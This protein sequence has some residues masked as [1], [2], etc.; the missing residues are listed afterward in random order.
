[1]KAVFVVGMMRSGTSLVEQIIASHPAVA[2]AGELSFWNDAVRKYNAL[3]RQEPL[4]ESL[5]RQLAEGYLQA[6]E[7]HSVDASRVVDKA[8]INSNYLGVIHSVFPNARIIYMRRDPIDTCLSCYFQPLSVSHSFTLDL[9]DL[10]HYYREHQRLMAH[11]R[12]VL[13]PGAILD[14]PYDQLVADQEGWTRKILDFVGLEW[15][16]RC[17]DFHTTARPV[18]TASYWQVRQRI[19][20]DSVQR[21]RHYRKFIGPLL[22][23]KE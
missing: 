17:L 16:P 6:L 18:A 13:P 21:W 22:D 19:Y 3:L 20:N 14:V 15:D 1:M 9:S 10:A 8:P 4:P 11:W 7:R 2:G 12:S 5:R 23:L